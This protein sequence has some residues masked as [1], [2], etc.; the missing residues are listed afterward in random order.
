MKSVKLTCS[1]TKN[2]TRAK[3]GALRGLWVKVGNLEIYGFRFCF[4]FVAVVSDES[5]HNMKL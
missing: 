4:C 2:K 3:I 1:R 5:K